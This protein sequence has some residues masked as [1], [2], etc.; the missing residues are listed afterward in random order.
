MAGKSKEFRIIRNEYDRNIEKTKFF[1]EGIAS[2]EFDV[3]LKNYD[4]D[5][6]MTSVYHVDSKS[7]SVP[8]EIK[9]VDNVAKIF[10]N[11]QGNLLREGMYEVRVKTNQDKTFKIPFVMAVPIKK[12][13]DFWDLK[14]KVNNRNK[15]EKLVN[16]ILNTQVQFLNLDSRSLILNKD[17]KLNT[18]SPMGMRLQNNK[19][20]W[21]EGRYELRITKAK[22]NELIFQ[23][24]YIVK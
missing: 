23:R 6:V 21:T 17:V 24:F 22:N 16:Q 10:F 15:N 18:S 5:T 13:Q 3:N 20:A 8:V 9:V 12:D 11:N 7:E 4:G 2:I 14:F 19:D 1:P